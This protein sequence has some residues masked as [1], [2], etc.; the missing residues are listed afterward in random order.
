LVGFLELDGCGGGHVL[1]GVEGLELGRGTVAERF[2]QTVVVEPADVLDDGELE[3]RLR[4]PDAVGDKL[5]L[6]GVDEALG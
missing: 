2:V 1:C 5:G 6:E 4:A 3:L